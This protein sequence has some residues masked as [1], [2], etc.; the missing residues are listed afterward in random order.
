LP[1]LKYSEY[2]EQD[3]QELS[4]PDASFDLLLTSETLEHIP[5]FRR[6][7]A[8]TR[9]VLRPGGRHLFTIPLDPQ[10]ERTRSR[11]GMTPV[12]HGRGGGPFA[13]VTRRNDMLVYTDFGQDVPDLL[14][15]A[16]FDVEVHGSGLE[17][18]FCA[19]AV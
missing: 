11:K 10:L 5:E 17:T 18:V 4:Y 7:L 6:A 3:I 9:R 12:Y 15:E 19:R 13:L 14:R 8:E 16:G 2:P 1:H